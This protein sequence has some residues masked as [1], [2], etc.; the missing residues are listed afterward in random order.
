M[1]YKCIQATARGGPEVLK[2][3]EY[4]IR[5]PGEGEVLIRVLATPVCQDDVA[6]RIGNR[7]FLPAIPFIPGYAVIGDVEQIGEGVDGLTAGDRI[8]A[9]T[10]TG[11]YTEYIYLKSDSLVQVPRELDPAEA[12]IL[13]LN[14]LTAYQCLHRAAKVKPGDK[15]LVIGA[16][17]GVG[18]AF[19]QL[20]KLAGLRMFGLA[21]EKNQDVITNL[22]AVP[23]DYKTQD[24]VEVIH[25]DLN[26]T[27]MH[28]Y[29]I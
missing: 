6:C 2:I 4:D 29:F 25:S 26:K 1:K 12:V 23:I 3:R 11:G 13:I 7:P 15:V 10:V 27:S 22:G 9:L 24:F 18:T 17:G 20:G 5:L 16:S 8:G 21:S 14:Y 19:L 28:R